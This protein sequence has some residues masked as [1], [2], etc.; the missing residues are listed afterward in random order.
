M[1]N[2]II[3]FTNNTKRKKTYGGAN[4]NKISILHSEKLHMLKFPTTPS[5]E[6]KLSYI[7]NCYSE[8]I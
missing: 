5:V 4:G 8:Y 1:I 2:T 7:H 6:T 3:D